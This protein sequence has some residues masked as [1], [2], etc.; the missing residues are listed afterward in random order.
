MISSLKFRICWSCLWDQDHKK[1][2]LFKSSSNV[3]AQKKNTF[4][5][6]LNNVFDIPLFPITFSLYKKEDIVFV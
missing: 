3:W 5:Q 1:S 4:V 2:F 6:V